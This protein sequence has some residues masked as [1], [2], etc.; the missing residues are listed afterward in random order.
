MEITVKAY[1]ARVILEQVAPTRFFA[2]L[3][4]DNRWGDAVKDLGRQTFLWQIK[5]WMKNTRRKNA[6]QIYYPAVSDH[7]EESSRDTA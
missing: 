7:K 4:N 1:P 6:D 5:I 3:E 2:T